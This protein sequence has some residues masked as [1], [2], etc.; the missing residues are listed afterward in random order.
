MGVPRMAADGLKGL[1]AHQG[2]RGEVKAQAGGEGQKSREI[3]K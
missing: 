1:V 2:P 3:M